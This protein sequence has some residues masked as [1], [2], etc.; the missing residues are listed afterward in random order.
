MDSPL[1][2]YNYYDDVSK[3]D[4]FID[5]PFSCDDTLD[6]LCTMLSADLSAECMEAIL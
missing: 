6:L 4:M 5:L 3:T 2:T 1:R